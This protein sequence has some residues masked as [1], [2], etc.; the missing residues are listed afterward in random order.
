MKR[1]SQREI[2]NQ[3]G[4]NVSTVSRA[5]RGL[6]GVSAELRQQVLA[7]AKEKGYRPNPFAV[8][9]RY[10]TTRTIGIIVPD[11]SFNHYAHIVKRIEADARKEGYMC[12]ITDS[13]DKYENE[14][15]CLEL[16]VNMHVEGIIICPSQDTNDFSHIQR[17]K[18]I[19]IPVVLFDRDADI[20]ISSV[21]IND[22]DSAR[23]AT[24]TLI[25]GGAKR[26]A[27]LGGPNKMK[28]TSERKHG[29]LEALRE[30]GLPIYKEL[31]KCNYVNYNSG[32]TDTLELLSLPEPPDA[33]IASHGMLATSAMKAI[34]SRGLR[35]PE[36]IALV[37]Y[38]S[39]WVSDVSSP[40]I[41]FV[42]QNQREIGTKAFKLLHD[43][44]DGD[45]CV[46]HVIVKTR[47]EL[48]EST[49]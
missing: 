40:R 17:L 21:V 1:V 6:E 36:D 49:K 35:I 42:R 4:V 19:H 2:A 28:Q 15:N 11:I 25:D 10:D 38:M 39:D 37:G 47:L 3:L 5:L 14:K 31:V 29:Y 22:A 16:L 45:T 27:F 18:K 43:Q 34:E 48:R 41:S 33:I 46:Q 32:L 20:D 8:S 24:N 30:R 26:I 9:L 7:L 13:D 12:I 44:L 23:Q